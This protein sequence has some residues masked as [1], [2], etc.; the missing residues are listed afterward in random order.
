MK[1][2]KLTTL[3]IIAASQLTFQLATAQNDH[4]PSEKIAEK[5]ASL[6]DS[7]LDLYTAVSHALYQ[8]NLAEAKNA[9][10]QLAK[11]QPAGPLTANAQLISKAN[12]ITDAR[13]HFHALSTT[14]IELA[15]DNSNYKLAHCPMARKNH[16]ASWLQ[17][18]N[19]EKV[20]NPY[21]GA[22]M[23]HCGSF[24]K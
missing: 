6:I 8:D 7:Q 2:N 17:K 5:P 11:V 15:K 4:K 3:F 22:Q 14:A 9:A 24:K 10:L 23:P 21:F 16:G 13:D 12:N 19:D 20:N 18:S 1:T